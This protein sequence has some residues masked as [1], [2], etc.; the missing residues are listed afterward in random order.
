M[1]TVSLKEALKGMTEKPSQSG[2]KSLYHELRYSQNVEIGLFFAFKQVEE[3]KSMY[4]LN[5]AQQT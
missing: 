2:L 3:V 1:Y 4:F 5:A